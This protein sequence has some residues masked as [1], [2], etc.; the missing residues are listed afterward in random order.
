MNL[1]TLKA[2]GQADGGVRGGVAGWAEVLWA[3]SKGSR[4]EA[5]DW[6]HDLIAAVVMETAQ[7]CCRRPPPGPW[8][9]PP[10]GQGW[11]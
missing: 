5:A 10:L 3:A 4:V 2:Q 9:G 8:S 1:F 7:F 11:G 6:R